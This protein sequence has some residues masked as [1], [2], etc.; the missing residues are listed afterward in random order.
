MT[1]NQKRLGLLLI[2]AGFGIMIV[3][4]AFNLVRLITLEGQLPES[5]LMVP[6]AGFISMLILMALVIFF[7]HKK[8]RSGSLVSLILFSFFLIFN[9]V[10]ILMNADHILARTG[11]TISLIFHWVSYLLIIGGSSIIYRDSKIPAQSSA[12]S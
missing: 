12:G 8:P 10:T 9:L 3:W 6:L 5:F 2:I 4:S 7:V 1:S 11:L